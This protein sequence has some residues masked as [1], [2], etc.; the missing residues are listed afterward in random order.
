[1]GWFLSRKKSQASSKRRGG[2]KRSASKTQ[3]PGWDPQRTLAWLKIAGSA[4]V[5]LALAVGWL[6]GR[7]ALMGYVNHTH[8][9]TPK[10]VDV[11]LADP[12]AWMSPG[13]KLR[14]KERVASA[15]AADPLDRKT[16]AQAGTN[17]LSDPVIRSAQVRRVS[18]GRLRIEQADYRQPV[19]IIEARDG[20]HLVGPKGTRLSLNPYYHHQVQPLGLP[21][22]LQVESAPPR[23]PGQR[24]QGEDVQAALSVIRLLRDKRYYDQI[25]AVDA[26]QRDSRGRLRLMLH[27]DDGQIAWGFPPGRERA[28]EPKPAQKLANLEQ[29]ARQHRGSIDAGGQRVSIYGPTPRIR[30]AAVKNAQANPATHDTP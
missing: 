12:P 23:G 25:T 1:M 22:I 13:T 3:N 7:S 5:V 28:I 6:Y 20:Y 10:P 24:W 15:L 4:A 27:T 21:L 2:G 8:G 18:G 19:A 29:V 26:S 14:L 11:E 16:L 9:Q 17:L 30:E